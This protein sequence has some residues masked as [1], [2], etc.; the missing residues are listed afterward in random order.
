MHKRKG[1]LLAIFLFLLIF[2]F[3]AC[4]TSFPEGE[5]GG[6]KI[7]L[8][9]ATFWPGENFYVTEGHN[10]WIQTVKE[11]VESQ[12]SHTFDVVVFPGELLL[13]ASEIYE[14]VVNGAADLGST[15]P[16]YTPG[17]FPATTALELP[18]LKND[19][20][21]VASV[22]MQEA[23]ETIEAI[24]NEY[25]DVKL[26]LF[27][28][29]GP[30]DLFT[31]SPVRNLQDLKGMEIRSVAS[32]VPSLKALGAAPV[33]M[34][35]GEA[36]LSLNQGIV[37]GIL[38]P[39]EILKGFRLAEVSKYSTKTPFLYNT[40]FMKVMNLET[41]NSLPLEVQEII[42]EVNA[43]FLIHYAGLGKIQSDLGQKLALESYGHEL[44]VLDKD[45]E[46][47]WLEALVDVREKWIIQNEK[48]G[49][50][51][52]EIVNEIFRLDQ[53]NS[54]LYGTESEADIR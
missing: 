39:A 44:I 1:F 29:T 15:C 3:S 21:I 19:N 23:Y 33:T 5:D 35:M 47:K 38:G 31:Q 2:L 14:G 51:A 46:A 12:T 28:S 22:T 4:G 24:N 32:S 50:P 6:L 48:K 42:D 26:M 54:A 36:Y 34:P 45:E 49:L 13:G 53:K 9:M 41:W 20:A 7:K 17:A 10:L 25:K 16:S 52:R 27:W 37:Q 43:E 11:R 8:N 30:G 40:V 18:G